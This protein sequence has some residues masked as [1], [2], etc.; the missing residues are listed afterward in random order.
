MVTGAS[1]EHSD[2]NGV[3]KEQRAR[4]ESF[5]VA[6]PLIVQQRLNKVWSVP[7]EGVE[8]EVEDA[9]L[10]AFC[11]LEWFSSTCEVNQEVNSAVVGNTYCA[12]GN[13]WLWGVDY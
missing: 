10:A 3:L 5:V 11:S 4:E 13:C 2:L 6:E 8:V 1:C 9:V 12:H 7:E